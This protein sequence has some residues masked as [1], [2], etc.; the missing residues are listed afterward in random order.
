M[1]W[2]SHNLYYKIASLSSLIGKN[3]F[4]STKEIIVTNNVI[5]SDRLAIVLIHCLH[6]GKSGHLSVS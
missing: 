3:Y 6:E 5:Q 2:L 4:F 1:I